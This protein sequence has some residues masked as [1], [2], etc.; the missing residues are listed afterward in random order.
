MNSIII[1][2]DALNKAGGQVHQIT[3]HYTGQSI[4][5]QSMQEKVGST[6]SE[7]SDTFKKKSIKSAINACKSLILYVEQ[8]SPI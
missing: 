8:S 5:A 7:T 1:I 2:G 3:F 6:D 4:Q